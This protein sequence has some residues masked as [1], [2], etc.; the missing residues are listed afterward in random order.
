[1][2]N[3]DIELLRS[4]VS[5]AVIAAG[6]NGYDEARHV[7]NAMIDRRPVVIVRCRSTRTSGPDRDHWTAAARGPWRR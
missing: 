2:S 5:G 4:R 3:P 7:Y 6:D 1:M